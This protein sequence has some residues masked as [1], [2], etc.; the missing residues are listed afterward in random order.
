MLLHELKNHR[1]DSPLNPKVCPSYLQTKGRVANWISLE[2]LPE[3]KYCF[4]FLEPRF[5]DFYGW[6]PLWFSWATMQDSDDHS[7]PFLW[8]PARPCF[9]GWGSRRL[10]SV[11]SLQLQPTIW[12]EEWRRWRWGPCLG[13]QP[14]LFSLKITAMA[15]TRDKEELHALSWGSSYT[16]D[17]KMVRSK[18]EI[19]SSWQPGS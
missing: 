14:A 8:C 15:G 18:A 3:P 19:V 5:Y 4:C 13:T 1:N 2:Q 10:H 11:V 9:F 16:S 12:T 7:S 6:H 17:G